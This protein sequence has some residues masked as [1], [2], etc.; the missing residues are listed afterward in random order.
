MKSVLV[1]DDEQSMYDFL[2][3]MLGKEGYSVTTASSGEEGRDLFQGEPFDIV[4]TDIRMPGIGGVGVLRAVKEQSAETPVI[5]ITAYSSV[6]SAVEAMKFGAYD[7]ITKPFKV[8]EIKLVMRN[9]LEKKVLAEENIV[10]RRERVAAGEFA[11][12]VGRGPAMNKL[13]EMI[14]QV[15]FSRSTVLITGESGT[16]KELVA[17]AM[18]NYGARKD[19]P[20]LSINCAALP[21]QLLESELFG[22]QRGAFTGAV[23]TKK[24]LLELAD[25]GTFFLDEVSEMSASLQVKLLR[26]LQEREFR[27]VGGTK[28]ISVDV[29][30]IA[31]SNADLARAVEEKQFREDLYYRLNVIP[32]E[33]PPLRSRKEDIPLLVGHFIKKYN[34]E[35]DRHVEGVAKDAMACLEACDWPGNVRELENVIERACT[36]E[37]GNL[38]SVGSLPEAIQMPE[39]IPE[40]EEVAELPKEGIDLE[41]ALADIERYYIE[42]ALHRT[43]G[44]KKKAA[45]M[46]NLSFRS[47][48]YRLKKLD[49]AKPS[50]PGDEEA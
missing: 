15:A 22:H 41:R 38:I 26:V 31:A 27:R 1:V 6:E 2:A 12:I 49:I 48:R 33:V 16:G 37:R 42:R 40:A 20:F 43:G 8:D 9:A 5:V 34:R 18:H 7:Y 17:R 25:G 21:E 13:Y 14:K 39:A 29:R 45:E 4:I 36:L 3:I 30:I 47:M 35:N 28:D 46:L 32:L 24:G 11:G 44:A 10:L 19:A 50:E 23:A